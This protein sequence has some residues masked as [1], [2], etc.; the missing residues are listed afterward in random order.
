MD[1]LG[2]S[3][4]LS[5]GVLYI[6]LIWQRFSQSNCTANVDGMQITINKKTDT[7]LTKIAELDNKVN[8]MARR[9]NQLERATLREDTVIRKKIDYLESSLRESDDRVR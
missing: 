8:D 1:L 3:S 4:L 7:I 5:S 6:Y 2:L 9:I